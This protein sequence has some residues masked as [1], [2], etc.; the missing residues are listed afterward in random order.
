MFDAPEWTGILP[1]R[2]TDR[3]ELVGVRF[4]PIGKVYHYDATGFQPIK[5][6]DWVIVDTARGKQMGQIAT[7]NPPKDNVAARSNAW[8]GWRPGATWRCATST[9][10]KSWR[11]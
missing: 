5:V 10:T 1:N 4:Q 9:R 2:T 11:P 6:K 7:V 8:S 3:A